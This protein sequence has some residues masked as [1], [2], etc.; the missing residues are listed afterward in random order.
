MSAHSKVS[1]QKIIGIGF[2]KTGTSSLRDALRIL[3]YQVGDTRYQL[4][5]AIL[6][7]DFAKVI[8]CLNRYDAVEDNPWCIIYQELDKRL[9][10]AKFILTIRASESWYQSVN[11]HIG[12]LR[13]PMH[14]WIYGRNKGLPKEDKA[15]TIAV[16]EK[17]NTTA[18]AY[19]KNRPED[20]LL[21]DFTKGDGWEELCAFLDKPIPNCPFPHANNSKRTP[22][23]TVWK[24]LKM[25]KKRIKYALQI[26]WFRWCG[27]L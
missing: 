24:Q 13:D 25:A 8:K 1:N 9:E 20:L 2:Q 18:L 11:R 21:L 7:G 26:R 14:E 27:L 6:R 12:E 5:P 16:Y 23:P 15:N 4:L 10:N 3:G 19:F 17:H 22:K